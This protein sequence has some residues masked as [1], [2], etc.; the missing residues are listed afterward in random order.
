M[1]RFLP[2]PKKE[3]LLATWLL[4]EEFGD[5]LVGRVFSLFEGFLI[6]KDLEELVVGVPVILSRRLVR[7]CTIVCFE[8]FHPGSG[9]YFDSKFKISSKT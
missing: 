8:L 6:F 4:V 3:R 7:L 9:H 5:G 2:D 1:A